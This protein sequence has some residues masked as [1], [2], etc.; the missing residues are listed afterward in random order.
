MA[1]FGVMVQPASLIPPG[2]V[3]LPPAA[4]LPPLEDIE[5]VLTGASKTLRGP[6]AELAKA[7]QQ[8]YTQ[9]KRG[10]AF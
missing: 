6:A 1:G 2:L 10:P 8:D 9:G 4:N 3:A 7:I 5:F